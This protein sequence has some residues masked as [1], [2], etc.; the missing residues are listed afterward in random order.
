MNLFPSLFRRL[1]DLQICFS[2]SSIDMFPSPSLNIL[3]PRKLTWTPKMAIFERRYM[4]KNTHHFSYLCYF[5]GRVG[6]LASFDLNNHQAS[7]CCS[8]RRRRHAATAAWKGAKKTPWL[9]WVPV[10][11]G[12]V[13]TWTGRSTGNPNLRNLQQDP[14]NGPSNLSI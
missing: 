12:R 13:I 1:L 14:V 10:P 11:S 4:L 9:R 8:M 7:S 3:H 2:Q 6:L 5:R